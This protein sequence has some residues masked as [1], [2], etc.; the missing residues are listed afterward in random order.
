MKEKNSDIKP[1]NV[2]LKSQVNINNYI[3]M[4]EYLKNQMFKTI[5]I[6]VKK[7]KPWWKFWLFLHIL[8]L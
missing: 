8:F 3:E 2:G 1:L 7:K 6:P 4:Q 5:G